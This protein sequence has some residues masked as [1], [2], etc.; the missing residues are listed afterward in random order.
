[1]SNQS[2]TVSIFDLEMH[3]C[4]RTFLATS[5]VPVYAARVSWWVYPQVQSH[6][7]VTSVSVISLVEWGYVC[8]PDIFVVQRAR[9]LTSFKFLCQSTGRLHQYLSVFSLWSWRPMRGHLS[10]FPL[11]P[12]EHI[13]FDEY[14]TFQPASKWPIFWCC[15]DL[16]LC[17][18]KN[19]CP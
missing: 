10:I 12:R 9:V 15:N 11:W 6:S 2:F 7:C 4:N 13:Y 17:T 1:M 3:P 8:L 14:P 16:H 18:W 19:S 5:T